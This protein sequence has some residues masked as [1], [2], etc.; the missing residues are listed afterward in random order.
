MFSNFRCC[1]C[2]DIC[3]GL[4]LHAFQQTSQPRPASSGRKHLGVVWFRLHIARWSCLLN[5]H[6]WHHHLPPWSRTPRNNKRC[7]QDVLRLATTAAVD[8]EK[9]RREHPNPRSFPT[10][11]RCKYAVN[12]PLW[13]TCAGS[14][15][16]SLAGSNGRLIWLAERPARLGGQ[17]GLGC[18]R[19]SSLL[20][21]R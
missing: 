19:T 6:V 1:F 18:A 4:S 20:C 13:Q 14:H 21:V 11:P 5:S 16:Y 8:A 15:S 2:T 10:C 17:W 9:H 7:S 3:K 12:K